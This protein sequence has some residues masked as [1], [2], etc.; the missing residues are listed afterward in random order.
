MSKPGI[1]APR[2]ARPGAEPC[3]GCTQAQRCKSE[4]LACQTFLS[5]VNSGT[6]QFNRPRHPSADTYAA[7][8][9]VE[10][11]IA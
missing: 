5:F 6:A 2:W 7:L 8:F 9:A 3:H 10:V 1:P 4:R 11:E